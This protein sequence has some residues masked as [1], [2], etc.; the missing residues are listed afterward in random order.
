MR[1]TWKA[2]KPDVEIDKPDADAMRTAVDPP[3]ANAA[4]E[5]PLRMRPSTPSTG[6]V[7]EVTNIKDI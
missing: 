1:A 3:L 2:Q 6:S 5:R 7:A 4:A